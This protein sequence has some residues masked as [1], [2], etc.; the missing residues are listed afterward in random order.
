MAADQIFV[1]VAFVG[2][3]LTIAIPA[4]LSHRQPPAAPTPSVEGSYDDEAI[5]ATQRS[6][7]PRA[8]RPSSRKR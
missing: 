5:T 3:V 7:P 8:H 6:R 4:V 1:L 2:V